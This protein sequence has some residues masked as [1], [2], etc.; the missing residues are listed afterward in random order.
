MASWQKWQSSLTSWS[1]DW[2]PWAAPRSTS[3]RNLAP[4]CIGI[5]RFDPPHDQGS[6]HG[7]TRITRQAIGEGREF[8]PL[9]LRSNEIW[10]ELEAAT[11]RNLMTRNGGLVLA[12]P[13]V[14]GKPPR[15]E[16]VSAG[17]HRRCE[18]LRH[19]APAAR[20]R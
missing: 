6:S 10:E 4:R 15:I 8:V 1:S 13:D 5:D 20:L 7:E 19:P 16:F 2:E 17:N 9:V 14:G 11:G 12:S 3:R 18:G